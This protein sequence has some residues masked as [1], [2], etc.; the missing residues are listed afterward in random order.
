[1]YN[2]ESMLDEIKSIVDDEGVF[3]PDQINKLQDFAEH[4]TWLVDA[5][6]ENFKE[7]YL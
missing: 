3:T 5:K 2:E 6:I 7:K 4:L 1:M